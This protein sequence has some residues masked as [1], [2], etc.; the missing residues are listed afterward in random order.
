MRLFMTKQ[1]LPTKYSGVRYREHLSRKIGPRMTK[2]KYFCIYYRLGEKIKWEAVGWQ[3]QGITAEKANLE[4]AGRK[5]NINNG[6]NIV[7]LKQKKLATIKNMEKENE[8]LITI[9][10]YWKQQYLPKITLRYKPSSTNRTESIFNKW[11]LPNI[12][13][14]QLSNL[15]KNDWNKVTNQIFNADIAPRTKEYVIGEIRRLL[16]DAKNNDIELGYMP[17]NL[18]TNIPTFNNRRRR[19]ISTTE[20]KLI[21]KKLQKKDNNAFQLTKFAFLTG[22]RLSECANVKWE[23]VY[24]DF[25]L[26]V[27]TKNKTN[28]KIIISESIRKLLNEMKKFENNH[29]I[30]TNKNGEIY[31][32][33]P[34]IFAKTVHEL[35]LNEGRE[36][37][38]KITFH[39]IRHSVATE[40]AKTLDIRTLMEFMGWKRMEMALRYIHNNYEAAK[41]AAEKLNEFI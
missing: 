8:R 22:C 32:Q 38:D 27:N 6:E 4:L 16:K 39:S 14:I 21:L 41:N 11:I 19:I 2:D 40:L 33:T 3:S 13:K 30:F 36:R 31:K 12:G 23:N 7:T 17:S 10:E 18:E 15:S 9:N 29:T 24:D 25:I 20:A 5:N 1:W 28:K 35:K 37:L 26:C 34:K